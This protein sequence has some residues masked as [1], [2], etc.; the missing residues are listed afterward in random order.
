[1]FHRRTRPRISYPCVLA[2]VTWSVSTVESLTTTKS[3]R[4]S[5]D[6]TKP[7]RISKFQSVQKEWRFTATSSPFSIKFGERESK[8]SV[9]KFA[10]H[11]AERV[12]LRAH[13]ELPAR[14]P[15]LLLRLRINC[16]SCAE[17][18]AAPRLLSRDG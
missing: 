14:R 3:C 1:M 8:K 18:R 17:L 10:P 5:S 16:R 13:P 12:L 15:L 4:S 11:Q 7:I 9:I 6:Y 2:Q